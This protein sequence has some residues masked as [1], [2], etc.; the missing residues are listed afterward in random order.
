MTMHSESQRGAMAAISIEKITLP[1]YFP[2]GQMDR[3]VAKT[4]KLRWRI[5]A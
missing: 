2:A 5:N 4:V 1:T 3:R